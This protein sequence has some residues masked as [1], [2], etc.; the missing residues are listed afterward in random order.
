MLWAAPRRRARRTRQIRQ[1]NASAPSPSFVVLETRERCPAPIRW[2]H[3]TDGQSTPSRLMLDLQQ[4][5]RGWLSAFAPKSRR[6]LRHSDQGQTETAVIDAEITGERITSH[7]FGM[8]QG[9]L[10]RHH[11]HIDVFAPQILVAI[12]PQPVAATIHQGDITLEPD[13]RYDK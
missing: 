10:L 5:R 4:K 7:G 3:A 8:K 13:I 6:K 12:N 2:D 9:D 1:R 11:A